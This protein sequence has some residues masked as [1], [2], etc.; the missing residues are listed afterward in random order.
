MLEILRVVRAFL[1]LLLNL[2]QP[3]RS[4]LVPPLVTVTI[5]V[6]LY[7]GWHV[8]DEGSL[9]AGLRV[10]FVDTRAYRTEHLRDLETAMLQSELSRTPATTKLID[11]LLAL[12][13]ERSTNVARVRLGVVHN[14]VLGVTGVALLRFDIT[15]GVASPGHAVGA[16]VTNE[17]LSDWNSFLPT[18]LAGKCHVSLTDAEDNSIR[19]ARLESLG[20]GASM[21]CPV[22][23]IEGR[24]LGAVL[25]TW[26]VRD[27]PPVG[28]ELRTLEAFARDICAQIAA[29]LDLGQRLPAAMRVGK[30]E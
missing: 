13:M 14:G 5:L 15:N 12:L 9:S 11:Q 4:L 6:F 7:A 25:A 2:G 1:E 23:D 29:A 28:D 24:M 19:R 16:V 21:V 22:I 17:P 8:R 20:A 26:D 3:L 30:H 10:A 18:L 27:A